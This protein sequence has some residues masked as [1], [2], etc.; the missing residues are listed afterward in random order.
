L[1]DRDLVLVVL[2]TRPEAIKLLPVIRELSGRS[3]LAVRVVATGQHRDMVDQILGP[4]GVKPDHDLGIMR[5][6]QTLNEIVCRVIPPL[7]HLYAE[8][9]PRMVLVQGDTTSAFAAALAAFHR[10]IPVGHVEAG[11]RTFDRLN[12]YPEETNRRMI[13]SVADLHLATTPGAAQNLLREGVPAEEIV[14]TGN[15]V[16][17]SLLGILSR[18]ELLEEF[19]VRDLP[20]G[21][22][23][24]LVLIT[25]HRRE[26]WLPSATSR[27]ESPLETVLLGIRDAAE[28]FPKARFVYPVHRN[29]R[30]QEPARRI[31]GERPNVHLLDPLAHIPFVDLMARSTVILTDSGGIQEEAPSLGVPV[32][33]ARETTERPEAVESGANRIVGT[34]RAEVAAALRRHLEAPFRRP[35]SRPFPSPYGD[36]RA[37]AR[38]REA[39]LFRLGRGGRPSDFRPDILEPASVPLSVQNPRSHGGLT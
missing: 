26:N 29:P 2:G 14:V 33:V 17:D 21:L 1:S 8:L 12:P 11:L 16:I 6:D 24:P 19:R 5:P 22:T 28:Q 32:L 23:D 37:S 27:G 3:D 18:P 20:M 10:R 36:G 9:A 13:T 7:D 31:L 34:G 15:T 35:G 30:V 38:I 25:L 39:V 4:F